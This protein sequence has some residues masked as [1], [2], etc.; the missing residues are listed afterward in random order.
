VKFYSQVG[1]DRVLF[2]NYFRGKRGGI[3]VDIGAYD[4]ET[5]SNT[6]FFERSMGW[7]GLCVEPIDSVFAKLR[8]VRRAMCEQVCVAD[9]EGEAEFTET[10]VAGIDEKMLSGLTGHF[11]PR[12]H[13]RIA[14]SRTRTRR[15]VSVTTLATLLERHGLYDVDYCSVDTEGAELAILSTLDPERFRIS[16]LTV[17]NNYDDDRLVRLMEEKN[18]ELIGKLEQD[19]IFKRRDIRPL[20][21][22]SVICAVWHGDPNRFELLRG[23][24][25][26]LAAQTVPLEPIYV[27]DGGDA[28][29]DWLSG[30][31]ISVKED[32]TIYQAWNLA[33]SVVATP[34]VMNLNLDDRL[35]PDA[36]QRME[37]ALHNEKAVAIG[38]DWKICYSQDETDAVEP[39]FPAARLPF[40]PEW[41]PKP[42]TQTRLGSGTA[43]RGTY[44][45]AT[46]WRTDV[47][48]NLP[49]FPWRL[50]DGSLVRVAGDAAWWSVLRDARKHKLV[51]LPIVIG[52]YH[53][54][55]ADQA[56][57]RYADEL[58]LLNEPGVSLL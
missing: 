3:F 8:T 19:Y 35:A 29:P 48:M 55:P 5:H 33:L 46:M 26:N 11:D 21:R 30:R 53:S 9:F 36:M 12:H 39:C 18:Y 49:R 22:V 1:Q 25:A 40:A 24:A 17:E 56:E 28:P 51:R 14:Y 50:Q 42:G 15:M 23:H 7:T 34:L 57:F 16:L 13:Q 31:I 4:G 37:I 2:E 47:H 52:N 20:P 41:P 43:N 45:P 44:G 32:L 10:E 38:G 27:F 54:H 6:L 58:P